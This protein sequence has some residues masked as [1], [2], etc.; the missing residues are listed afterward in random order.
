MEEGAQ[1]VAQGQDASKEG[2][3]ASGGRPAESGEGD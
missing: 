3:A 2:A 1:D